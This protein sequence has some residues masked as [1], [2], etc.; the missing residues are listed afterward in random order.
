MRLETLIRDKDAMLK[1]QAAQAVNRNISAPYYNLTCI[2][3]I[4][5]EICAP[6]NSGDRDPIL[7]RSPVE[8]FAFFGASLH[9]SDCSVQDLSLQTKNILLRAF[10]SSIMII[11]TAY[12][13]Q[14]EYFQ[15]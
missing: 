1:I 9:P 6:Y 10:W 2:Y 13:T 3:T 7:S 5:S 12:I 4:Y 14:T 8:P 11:S 15:V